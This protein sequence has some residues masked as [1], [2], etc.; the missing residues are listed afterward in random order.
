MKRAMILFTWF[1]LTFPNV[2]SLNSGVLTLNSLD[3]AAA[4]TAK[5]SCSGKHACVMVFNLGDL[6]RRVF[7]EFYLSQF[8]HASLCPVLPSN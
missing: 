5:I 4:D 6:D 3:P 8:Q 1:C 2:A 7:E